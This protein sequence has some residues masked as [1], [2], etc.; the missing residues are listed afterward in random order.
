MKESKK[1]ILGVMKKNIARDDKFENL[2]LNLA[3]RK[4]NGAGKDDNGVYYSKG[5]KHLVMASKTLEGEYTVKEG[6]ESIEDNAFW[7]CAFVTKIII[8]EGVKTIGDEAFGRCLSLKEVTVPASVEKMGHNPFVGLDADAVKCQSE[9]YPVDAKIMYNADHTRLVACLTDAALVIIPRSV[10]EISDFAFARRRSLRKVV[11]PEGVTHIG[12]DAFCDCDALE[13]VSIPSTV[14]DI[15]AYAFSDCDALRRVVFAGEVKHIHRTA[16]ADCDLLKEVSV[17]AD[18]AARFRKQL[19]MA[20]ESEMYIVE[21]EDAK[22]AK[23]AA[24]PAEEAAA[25][26]VAEPEKAKEEAAPAA[27]PAKKQKA[28]KKK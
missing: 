21:R 14:T 6:T 2:V 12:A 18:T 26:P 25:A 22:V 17:P 23:P 8:P 20:A 15:D 19:R 10:T 28:D 7:G 16:F 9:A 13:E 5:Q 1:V 4:M 27:E 11:I 24:K 3:L